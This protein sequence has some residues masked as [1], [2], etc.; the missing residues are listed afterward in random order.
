VR[1]G[2]PQRVLELRVEGIGVELPDLLVDDGKLL[3]GQLE[4][5][6]AAPAP[7]PAD[8]RWP[9]GAEAAASAKGRVK[10]PAAGPSGGQAARCLGAAAAAGNA[11]RAALL[12]S[13]APLD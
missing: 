3:G 10:L 2:R 8:G 4:H 1:R 9:G 13:A 6:G 11:A 12:F 7:R 5:R